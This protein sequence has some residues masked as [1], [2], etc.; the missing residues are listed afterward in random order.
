MLPFGRAA[1][2]G[3]GADGCCRTVTFGRRPSAVRLLAAYDPARAAN[4]YRRVARIRPHRKRLNRRSAAER[5]LQISNEFPDNIEFFRLM[6]EPSS[7]ASPTLPLFV[8]ETLLRTP[9]ESD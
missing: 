5:Q 4:E 7:T 6:L 3:V 8:A 1:I 9:L 2:P